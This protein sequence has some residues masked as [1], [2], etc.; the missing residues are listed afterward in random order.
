[1]RNFIKIIFV[2]IIALSITSCASLTNSTANINSDKWIPFELRPSQ[3]TKN[4][5]PFFEG[6]LSDNSVF[7]V[8][9]DYTVS[10]DGTFYYKR[11]M[12]D[13][14]WYENTK[15]GWSGNPYQVKRTQTG[16][17]YVNPKKL[18]GIYFY[19]KGTFDA[20]KIK[21]IQWPAK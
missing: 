12:Q 17:I 15:G 7:E 13:F 2:S 20:F 10:Q 3:I 6:R 9:M 8:Y 4:G 11:L 5:D 14:G 18:V 21:F 1:M 16:Y 19:P